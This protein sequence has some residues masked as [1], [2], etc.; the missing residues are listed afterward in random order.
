MN[1]LQLVRLTALMQ[2]SSGLPEIAIALIDGPVSA[3]QSGRWSKS[4]QRLGGGGHLTCSQPAGLSCTHGTFVAGILSARRDS[5]APGICPGCTLL[6]RAV[7]TEDSKK[8]GEIPSAIPSELARAIRDG[9]DAGARVINLSLSVGAAS[10]RD[11]LCVET[12]LSYA[13]ARGVIIVAAAG[14]QGEI[15][16]SL[17]SRHPWPIPVAG[18]DAHGQ[19]TANSNLGHSIGKRGL[20]AP[21]ENIASLTP[22]G[23][24][25]TFS[26]T[27]AAAPF[28]SG[29]I[30][31]LWSKFPTASAAA[32]K[33]AISGADRRPRRAVVP[34]LL[35]AWMAYE[36]LSVRS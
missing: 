6:I 3:N 2:V 9:V 27:S 29:T 30:G 24:I 16:G 17:L 33:Q 18:C 12:A 35:D 31:L 1:P 8:T 34:P 7:F 13:A 19:P 11:K 5:P 10:P 28:V 15:G 22:T 4:M 23:T 25:E 21:S 14:N 36:T 20:R 32:V 26:G